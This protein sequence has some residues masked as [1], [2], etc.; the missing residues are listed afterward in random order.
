[1]TTAVIVL[2]V[3]TVLVVWGIKAKHSHLYL[4]IIGVTLGVFVAA[5]PVGPAIGNS[6]TAVADAFGAAGSAIGSSIGGRR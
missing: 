3:L 2:I 5:T 1:M 4:A 6:V